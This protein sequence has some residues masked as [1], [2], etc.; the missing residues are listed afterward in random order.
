MCTKLESSLL[1]T[2]CKQ[3][4]DSPQIHNN[5]HDITCVTQLSLCLP[6]ISKLNEQEQSSHLEIV[7]LVILSF[8]RA[9]PRRSS[10]YSRYFKRVYSRGSQFEWKK[11]KPYDHPF[12]AIA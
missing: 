10:N 11:R 4:Q 5:F 7:Q 2:L 12:V 3:G 9:M 6:I 8:C 1:T